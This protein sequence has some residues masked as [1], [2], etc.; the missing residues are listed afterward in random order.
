MEVRMIVSLTSWKKRIDGCVETIKSLLD[1]DFDD[2][3]IELNL[4][5]QNFPLGY[6]ELPVSLL[7]LTENTKFKIKW[8]YQDLKCWQKIAPTIWRHREESYTI[9]TCD[10]DIT[11]PRTYLSEIAENI[12]GNDWMC[13]RWP[14]I[15][16]GQYMAYGPRAI[17]ALLHHVDLNLIRNCPLDDHPIYWIIKK[18]NLKRGAPIQSVPVDR[19][20]G[21]SFRRYFVD[22]EDPSQLKDSSCDYPIEQFK[23]E[24]A[25]MHSVG[26]C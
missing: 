26:I 6:M 22:V 7:E 3:T 23:R 12:K 19:K 18:Y 4:D 10:D 15:T 24:R 11:Y 16:Q 8:I 2:Y 14:D 5:Y 25:Y 9:V 13:T 1:Q 17:D 21:Y 20:E